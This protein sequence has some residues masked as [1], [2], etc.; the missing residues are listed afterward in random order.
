MN[1]KPVGPNARH[2]TELGM[3]PK[4]G[5]I[6]Y[7]AGNS[8]SVAAALAAINIPFELV[9]SPE[10]LAAVDAIVMPGVGS[11]GATMDSLDELDLIAPMTEFVMERRRPYLGICVG[12]QIV[13]SHSEE[14]DASCLGWL[15]GTVRQ[16]CE[17]TVRVPQIG[18]NEVQKARDHPIFGGIGR[19]CYAYFVNSYHAFPEQDDVVIGTVDY[20]A[21][22]G[23][24]SARGNLNA[25]AERVDAPLT[26]TLKG[27]GPFYG[28]P[29]NIGQVLLLFEPGDMLRS[30]RAAGITQTTG[31]YDA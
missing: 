1:W 28:H 22:A 29:K 24:V 14:G 4:I 20:L 30:L 13:F 9:S 19:G 26:T 23:A 3:L 25:V 8:E 21:G 6:D 18:W 12:L 15:P 16:F 11:A 27:T 10:C 5:I 2:G 31:T 17:A 7:R